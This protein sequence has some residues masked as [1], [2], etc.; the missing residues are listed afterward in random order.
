MFPPLTW[1][2]FFRRDGAHGMTRP[3][4]PNYFLA[5]GAG[6][7]KH[8]NAGAKTPPGSQTKQHQETLTKT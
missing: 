4:G 6:L 1:W 8:F 5:L 2:R 3:A 7:A